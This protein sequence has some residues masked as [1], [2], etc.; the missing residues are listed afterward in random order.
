MNT[1]VMISAGINALITFLTALLALWTAEGVAS[2]ADVSQLSYLVAA[3]G[4]ILAFLK[5]MQSRMAQPPA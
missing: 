1:Q 3:V 4:S 5:D 2:L